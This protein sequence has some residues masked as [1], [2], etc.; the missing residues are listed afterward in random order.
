MVP[1]TIMVS[2]CVGAIIPKFKHALANTV[3]ANLRYD[4][5]IAGPPRIFPARGRL[6]M[7]KRNNQTLLDIWIKASMLFFGRR[8]VDASVFLYAFDLI[9]LNGDDLRRDPIEFNARGGAVPDCPVN[10]HHS[11]PGDNP[12]KMALR[13]ILRSCVRCPDRWSR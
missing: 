7:K 1:S 8:R 5:D 10:T 2:A 12:V 3:E 13:S 4:I 6:I 11:D 9:E